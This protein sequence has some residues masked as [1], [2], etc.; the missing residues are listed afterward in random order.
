M[1]WTDLLTHNPNLC[2]V[3]QKDILMTRAA[4]CEGDYLIIFGSTAQDMEH[5]VTC[6]MIQNIV[7]LFTLFLF[8]I[9]QE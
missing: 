4:I 3:R 6:M 2:H 8:Q 9:D 1:A 5:D 7:I